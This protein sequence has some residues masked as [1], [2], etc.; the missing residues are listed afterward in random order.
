M[1]SEAFSH[2]ICTLTHITLLQTTMKRQFLTKHIEDACEMQVVACKYPRCNE[3]FTKQQIEH[4]EASCE[5]GKSR[6][7]LDHKL[8][9]ALQDYFPAL[10]FVSTD[11]NPSNAEASLD[12]SECPDNASLKNPTLDIESFFSAANCTL[13][14]SASSS[15]NTFATDILHSPRSSAYFSDLQQK[16]IE[17]TLDRMSVMELPVNM[18]GAQ[19]TRSERRIGVLFEYFSGEWNEL[20]DFD[21][22]TP[23]RVGSC[24]NISIDD[25]TEQ[26]VFLS[27]EMLC[28]PGNFAA[29]FTCA[30]T[31]EQAGLYAFY[32][33]SNDGSRLS[34]DDAI[35]I[36][37]DGSH[38][39]RQ[40]SGSVKLDAGQHTL[41]VEFFHRNGKIME[42]LRTGPHL[43]LQY[44]HWTDAPGA[45]IQRQFI[46]DNHL[47][48]TVHEWRLQR[49]LLAQEARAR[50][51][52]KEKIVSSGVAE[53]RAKTATEIASRELRLQLDVAYA[54]IK[55]L[56]QLLYEQNESQKTRLNCLKQHLDDAN[57]T[58]DVYKTLLSLSGQQL[59]QSKSNARSA[60]Q[61]AALLDRYQLDATAV[62]KSLLAHLDAVFAAR[63]DLFFSLVLAVKLDALQR[64]GPAAA[65]IID[66][67]D[68]YR[69]VI[70]DP[71]PRL[72][73]ST[74][75]WP[76][77]ISNL[78]YDKLDQSML[79]C[80]SSGD[81][82][83]SDTLYGNIENSSIS[84]TKEAK[85]SSGSIF[86]RFRQWFFK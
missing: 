11:D 84:C 41:S 37:N 20:P 81:V 21:A 19:Q 8:N 55:S 69:Q 42:A 51:L 33:A 50:E 79:K 28:A 56:E 72:A 16:V 18:S 45:S 65:N 6:N 70:D 38:Y 14:E 47:T 68:L 77:L 63:R 35:I 75:E 31:T 78:I 67:Q 60:P 54:T 5:F 13:N 44:A 30:V 22:V 64:L 49:L 2:S 9:L 15:E 36:E 25:Q 29:R 40:V 62:P 4:H 17:K 48:F 10:S 85:S 27:N 34:I 12:R 73:T 52:P 46:P 32:L 26:N 58:I 1:F 76:L 71:P 82:D 7:S 74:A 59:G 53:A 80:R 3:R 23:T 43:S 24:S 39:V 83:D 57:R 66:A 86:F 61:V